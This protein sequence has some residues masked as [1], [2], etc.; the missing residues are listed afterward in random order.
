VSDLGLGPAPVPRKRLAAG[1]LAEALR[2]LL[3]NEF[4]AERARL[5]GAHLRAADP[6]LPHHRDALLTKLVA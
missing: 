5:L 3:G 2:S 1:P 4:V 6:L